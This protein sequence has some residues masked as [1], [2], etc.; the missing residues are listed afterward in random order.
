MIDISGATVPP[1]DVIHTKKGVISF[2]GG[3]I[4]NVLVRLQSFRLKAGIV[5]KVG[6]DSKGKLIL[7]EIKRH[8]LDTKRLVIGKKPTYSVHFD[9]KEGKSSIKYEEN[10][11]YL[12][13]I[14]KDDLDYL[15][16]SK[17]IMTSFRCPFFP[18]LIPKLKNKIFVTL[19]TAKN[20]KNKLSLLLSKNIEIIFCNENEFSLIKNIFYEILDAGKII[21]RTQGEKGCTVFTKSEKKEYSGFKVKY[22]DPTGA[23]DAFA[24][25]F[26]YGYMKGWDMNRTADFANACGALA[27][28]QYGARSVVL[29]VEEVKKFIKSQ[30]R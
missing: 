11:W 23:G 1:M 22:I 21:V 19:N 6:N 13:K 25:G 14:D 27:T 5:G 17:Y 2:P 15:S 12:N 20:S 28:T 7:T 18:E 16:S 9:V 4:V 8:G 3:Y 10:E 24:A 26:I 29:T 30:K